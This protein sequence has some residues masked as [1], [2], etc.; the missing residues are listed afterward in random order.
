MFSACERDRG[1]RRVLNATALV[2]AF[3]LP[4]LGGLRL[5]GCRV[6]RTRQ[7]ALWT[8]TQVAISQGE[9]LRGSFGRLEIL[10]VRGACSRRED[11]VWSRGNV[12]GSPVFAFFT[13]SGMVVHGVASELGFAPTKA[14]TLGAVFLMRQPDASRSGLESD[15]LK[16][17]DRM[18]TKGSI[19]TRLRQP[20]PSCRANALVTL[21]KRVAYEVGMFYVVNVLSGLRVRGYET[22]RS[23]LCCVVRSRFDPFEVCP[24]V[25]TVVTAVVACGVPEWWHSFGYGWYLYPVWVMVCGGMSYSSLF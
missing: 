11:V 8:V 21:T 22:E 4:L 9:L 15:T 12:K 1:V 24:G 2:V 5:H 13:K 25:G 14:T 16:G 10:K 20:Y 23:F 18:A 17:R 3:L 6:S 19:A 7:S